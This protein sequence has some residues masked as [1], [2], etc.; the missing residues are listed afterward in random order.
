MN[1]NISGIYRIDF[2]GTGWFYIGS[3]RCIKQ[4]FIDHKKRLKKGNHENPKMQNIYN[5]YG[6]PIYKIIEFCGLDSLKERENYYFEELKP[7][8]N[9]ILDSQQSKR[10]LKIPKVGNQFVFQNI[11][12][13]E[14]KNLKF[15]DLEN[16]A[17]TGFN[18]T[19]SYG[20]FC[21]LLQGDLYRC[22]DWVLLEV[23]GVQRRKK[24]RKASDS[25]K[26][27]LSTSKRKTDEKKFKE[28]L[29]VYQLAI[30]YK[31]KTGCSWREV[32][33]IS[34]LCREAIRKIR[35]VES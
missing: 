4:R 13:R 16:F 28:R 17:R 29:W 24:A 1:H 10:K 15:E 8:I 30:E 11:K 32:S 14:V 2:L 23:D 19:T 12:T 3:T 33:R 22:R 9:I 26:Q 7:N 25:T 27:K 5:K 21:K 35:C 31:E 20:D 6:K 34:G 18:F